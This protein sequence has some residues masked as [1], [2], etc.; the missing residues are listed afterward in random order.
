M[1]NH[2]T[3]SDAEMN[4]ALRYCE[5][6]LPKVSRTFAINIRVL[7]DELYLAV[8]VAYLFC[9]LVDT[10]EDSATLSQDAQV[11]LLENYTN[12]FSGDEP[13]DDDIQ[14]WK[15]LWGEVN[16][17]VPELSLVENCDKVF[18]LFAG[19][20]PEYRNAI[21]SC[22]VE[23]ASGMRS[24]LVD[25]P[26]CATGVRSLTTIDDLEQYCYYVAGTV[27]KMLSRLFTMETPDLPAQQREVME[28]NDISFALGLQLT[29][30]IKD[31]A[32]DFRRGWCY[33]PSAMLEEVGVVPSELLDNENRD[34]VLAVLNQLIIKTAD[35]LGDALEYTLAIP[36]SRPRIRLFNL[37][38]LFFAV[39]TL[40]QAWNNP[41][42]LDPERK[43]KI[44][45]HEIYRTIA[46]TRDAVGSD[47]DLRRLFATLREKI[48]SA[49]DARF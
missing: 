45:R 9:R 40:V 47:S 11:K 14:A 41:D 3:Y 6:I 23:M 48:P 35:H 44:P 8:L 39:R 20:R 10:V 30:I 29:N 33:I 17:D 16:T 1:I 37:W 15:Q 27:G 18:A 19:L 49:C 22:V 36:A 7:E 25:F 24:T 4:S 38:S 12:M 31:C 13:D 26:P 34:Q 43:V 2:S 46:E 21:R 42:L 28:R 5:L 32:T